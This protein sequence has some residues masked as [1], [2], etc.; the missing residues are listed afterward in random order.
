[1]I[2]TSLLLGSS[3]SLPV[4]TVQQE[5]QA[6]D[7]LNIPFTVFPVPPESA[8]IEFPKS[9]AVSDD[10]QFRYIENAFYGA[11]TFSSH[12]SASE[13]ECA[14][15]CRSGCDFFV[16]DRNKKECKT[17][18]WNKHAYVG[19]VF[20]GQ[21]NSNFLFGAFHYNSPPRTA[22]VAVV[23]VQDCI[24]KCTAADNCD[25]ASFSYSQ[26]INGVAQGVNSCDF[27]KFQTVQ[28][29]VI[30][31]QS[32]PHGINENPNLYGRF[33]V[34][35]NSGIV[36]IH[37]TLLPNGNILNTARPEY[38]RGG[39]NPDNYARPEVPYGEIAAVF[40]VTTGKTFPSIVNDNIFCHAVIQLAN[41]DFFTAGGD[42]YVQGKDAS[43]GLDY[44]L[45]VTRLYNVAKNE[46]KILGKMRMARWYPTALRLANG[47]IF[48]IGGVMT[49][50]PGGIQMNIEIYR[51]GRAENPLIENELL[52]ANKQTLYPI[53]HLI[54]KTGQVFMWAGQGW[55]KLDQDAK[56]IAWNRAESPFIH[57]HYYP[58]GATL[59][60][61][62]PDNNYDADLLIFGGSRGE[63][64]VWEDEVAS[65]RVLRIRITY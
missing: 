10:I 62:D 14:Q 45:D 30:G 57:S 34:I 2:C 3:L 49:A 23:G 56:Q 50:Q 61:L 31:Y 59:L 15:N 6:D 21:V 27:F 5:K 35:G 26:I 63:N 40:N 29:S 33:D 64:A 16:F 54:P 8:P 38:E 7:F 24:Q 32:N 20:S 39:P 48:I 47:D 18:Y 12:Q 51:E 55:A 17:K 53:A 41:G 58:A 52:F 4:L 28:G 65:N 37:A 44:G 36:G 9:G 43:R 13:F 11:Y 22:T 42:D 60:A 1:M 19:T 25:M 46:W